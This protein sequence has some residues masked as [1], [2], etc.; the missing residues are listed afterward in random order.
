MHRPDDS[1]ASTLPDAP[2]DRNALPTFGAEELVAD[3]W[4]I[5]RLIDRGGMGEVYE[6]E[7]LELGERVALKTVRPLLAG[8]LQAIERFKR[9]TA[10]ARKVTHPN[11]CRIFDIGVHRRPGGADLFFLTM[12]LLTGETLAQRLRRDGRLSETEALPLARQLGAALEAA[13]AAGVVHRDL[14]SSNVLLVQGESGPRAVVTDFGLACS[15]P[16]GEGIETA[17]SENTPL[18]GTPDY[19]APEQVEGGPVTAAADLFALGV[20]LYEIVTGTLPFRGERPL[21]AALARLKEPPIP[22]TDT[23]RIWIRTGPPPSCAAWRETRRRVRPVRPR[24]WLRWRAGRP[25]RACGRA[26]AWPSLAFGTCRGARTP[27][28]CRQRYP[29]CWAPSLRR[30]SRSG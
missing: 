21:D 20:V 18:V 16:L 30:A 29:K 10:L 11:V 23:Y 2:L 15:G 27:R 4:R 7:D 8:R 22:P 9:E 19:M 14:K 25:V 1:A 12:E 17:E 24:S 3:R 5:I 26:V 28:G 6:A 13:H